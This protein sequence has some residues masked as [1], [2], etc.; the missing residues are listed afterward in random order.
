M[1]VLCCHSNIDFPKNNLKKK[2]IINYSIPSGLAL[3]LPYRPANAKTN[4]KKKT[5]LTFKQKR[6]YLF[7]NSNNSNKKNQY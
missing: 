5:N 2:I 6:N 3:L 4:T 1:I 7:L